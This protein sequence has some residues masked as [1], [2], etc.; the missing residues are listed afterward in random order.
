MKKLFL[1]MV[2]ASLISGC[3]TGPDYDY[4]Y[5]E[6]PDYSY[7]QPVP[8]LHPSP[9]PPVMIPDATA[10]ADPCYTDLVSRDQWGN[11]IHE[12]TDVRSCEEI[13][14]LKDNRKNHQNGYGE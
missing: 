8:D 9:E 13:R 11:V 14:A 6:Y 5:P 12:E 3:V 4:Y 10:E 1:L 2:I 7:R